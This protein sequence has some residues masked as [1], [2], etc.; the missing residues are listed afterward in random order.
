MA[1]SIFIFRS[2]DGR[3]R[4]ERLLAA[5][6][7]AGYEQDA[8]GETASE[9]LDI[10]RIARTKRGKPYFPEQPDLHFS[11]SHSGDFWVCAFSERPVGVDIQKHVKRAGE[12]QTQA[13]ARLARM[14]ERFFHPEETAWVMEYPYKRFFQIWTAKES[15]VKYTGEG[16]GAGFEALCLAP[17]SESAEWEQTDVRERS[18]F[19]WKANGLRFCSREFSGDSL[20]RGSSVGA[21]DSPGYTLCVCFEKEE[22]SVW[23]QRYD[24]IS[25]NCGE[26]E[27]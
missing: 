19:R 21:G 16:I 4:E 13:A 3:T 12:S 2:D 22:E 26:R 6:S 8:V 25:E 11:I 23:M 5:A 18:S 17:D 27:E 10:W 1:V 9:R 15:Y 14:A 24:E 20:V 7:V